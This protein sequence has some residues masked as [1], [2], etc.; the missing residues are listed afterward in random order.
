MADIKANIGKAKSAL[1]KL[2]AAAKNGVKVLNELSGG[3]YEGTGLVEQAPERIG[4]VVALLNR[5]KAEL[6]AQAGFDGLTEEEVAAKQAQDRAE[7]IAGLQ[8][9]AAAH[10]EA[11]LNRNQPE[12]VTETDEVAADQPPVTDVADR[13]PE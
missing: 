4:E 5:A 1:D 11:V 7:E 13:K 12:T 2:A 3:A 6:D 9:A 10:L 8:A